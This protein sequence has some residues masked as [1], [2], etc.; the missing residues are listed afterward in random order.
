MVG[1]R[2]GKIVNMPLE[3]AEA[4]QVIYYGVTQ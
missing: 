4:F 1:E 3:N 2:I